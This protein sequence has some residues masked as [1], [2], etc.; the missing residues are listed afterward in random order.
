MKIYKREHLKCKFKNKWN[1]H[2]LRGA[3]KPKIPFR[4]LSIFTNFTDYWQISFKRQYAYTYLPNS[5]EVFLVERFY[6][7][8]RKCWV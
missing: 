6:T 8:F 5:V 7:T 1:S 3:S 2:Y 4:F